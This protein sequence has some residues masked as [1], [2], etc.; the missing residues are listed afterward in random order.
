MSQGRELPQACH[1]P[2]EDVQVCPEGS[3]ELVPPTCFT[4]G[5]DGALAGAPKLEGEYLSYWRNSEDIGLNRYEPEFAWL[6]EEW[7]TNGEYYV[8]LM[9]PLNFAYTEDLFYFC[10]VHQ[11]LGARIKL[12]RDGRIINPLLLPEHRLVPPP[13]SGYD[14]RCGTYGLV[15]VPVPPGIVGD[16]W[17]CSQL[18][19]YRLPTRSAPGSLGARG[20]SRPLQRAPTQSNATCSMA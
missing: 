11:Y 17:P 19:D 15:A 7:A 10:H 6:V 13:P 16:G 8:N 2:R 1:G 9:L 3:Y 20:T 4:Y 14:R 18:G 5:P 12:K